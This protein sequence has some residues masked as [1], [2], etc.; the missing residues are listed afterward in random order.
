MLGNYLD[1]I[2][3][4]L[5]QKYFFKKPSELVKYLHK[6]HFRNKVV[7]QTQAFRVHLS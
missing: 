3:L 4:S 6:G 2:K 7:A 1:M 5:I